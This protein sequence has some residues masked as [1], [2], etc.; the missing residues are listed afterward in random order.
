VLCG[1]SPS[2]PKAREKSALHLLPS[3]YLQEEKS[4]TID[5][6]QRTI[7]DKNDACGP[8]SI[9]TTPHTGHLKKGFLACFRGTAQRILIKIS[10]GSP[11][12]GS[13]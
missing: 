2:A 6:V 5:K 12:C 13:L 7:S 11:C 9:W 1:I 3:R 10:I 8:K 4:P